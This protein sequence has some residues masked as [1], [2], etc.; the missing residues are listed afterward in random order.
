MCVTWKS[1]WEIA[2]EDIRAYK[3]VLRRHDGTCCS[4]LP[5]KERVPQGIGDS[6]QG[7]VVEYKIGERVT[8][9][10]PGIYLL[11][12][13][14]NV[15]APNVVME[16]TIPKGTWFRRG[17]SALHNVVGEVFLVTALNAEEIVVVGECPRQSISWDA[18]FAWSYVTASTT[19]AT[20]STL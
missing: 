1:D 11:E 15:E 18:T 3:I 13:L 10:R 9:S 7:S 8:S 14:I 2:K 4:P 6:R 12:H 5:I 16:V 17:E 20:T 19:T